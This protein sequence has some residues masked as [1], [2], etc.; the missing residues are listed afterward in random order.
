[1]QEAYHIQRDFSALHY[2]PPRRAGR[3]CYFAELRAIF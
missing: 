1:V 2:Q 3:H